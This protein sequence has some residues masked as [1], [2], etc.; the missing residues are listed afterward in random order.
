MAAETPGWGK[1]VAD[2]KQ[3]HALAKS[4]SS[5]AAANEGTSILKLNGRRFSLEENRDRPGKWNDLA[6]I[7]VSMRKKIGVK[8]KTNFLGIVAAMKVSQTSAP[9]SSELLMKSATTSP[10]SSSWH[11]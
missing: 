4:T 10:H 1:T 6:L 11:A 2:A 5:Q 8:S 7:D 3:L 9:K